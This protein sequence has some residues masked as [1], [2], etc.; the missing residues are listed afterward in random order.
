MGVAPFSESGM[1]SPLLEMVAFVM[2]IPTFH[3]EV[4]C[5]EAT[6]WVSSWPTSGLIGPMSRWREVLSSLVV[7]PTPHAEIT[8]FE[9]PGES[10]PRSQVTAPAG[11]AAEAEPDK[12]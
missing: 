12:V 3:D 11:P 5:E 2:G 7:R 1:T 9:E 4:T 10:D 6:L 8:S